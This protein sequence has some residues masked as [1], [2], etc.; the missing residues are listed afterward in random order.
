M[1]SSVSSLSSVGPRKYIY[2]CWIWRDIRP[3]ISD[4]YWILDRTFDLYRKHLS[5]FQFYFTIEPRRKL[6]GSY[7]EWLG[8]AAVLQHVYQPVLYWRPFWVFALW[9]KHGWICDGI[10]RDSQILRP[11]T[12][13]YRYRG[14]L[15]FPHRALWELDLLLL[16][17]TR[18]CLDFWKRS[19][20]TC[21]DCN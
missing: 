5:L 3:N 1:L 6:R 20:H 8:S 13:I 10:P 16:Y 19:I 18:S 4:K 2:D 9:G 17:H 7:Q 14:P 15:G 12:T 21:T 11:S